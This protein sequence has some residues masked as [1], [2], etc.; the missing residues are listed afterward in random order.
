MLNHYCVKTGVM[1]SPWLHAVVLVA[2]ALPYFINLGVSSVWDGSE[3]F[4]AE[5]PREM[6]ATGDWLSPQFNFEP[7]VNK[8]PLTY[9]AVLVSYKLLG[10]HEFAVRLPGALAAL[11][12]MLFSWGAARMLFGSGAALVA[13]TIAAT[14]P[15][16]FILERRL[17]IDILLLF[18]LAGTLFFL[19]RGVTKGTPASWYGVYAFAALGFLTKGPVAVIVP[20]GALLCWMA[21]AR[22]MRLPGMRPLHGAAIF[23]CLT[24]PYYLLSYRVNGWTYIAPFFL[25]DNLGRFASESFGP[26]RGYFYYVLIWFS[27]FF[28]WAIILPAALFSL[29]RGLRERLKDPAFGLP[30]FWCIVIFL[31]FSLS[32]NKQEYYIAPMYPAAAILV[33]GFAGLFDEWRSKLRSRPSP[34]TP[35]ETRS[36]RLVLRSWG[37]LYGFLALLLFLMAFTLPYILDLLMPGVHFALR[38]VPS[39]ILVAGAVAMIRSV[40]RKDFHVAFA[41]LSFSLWILFFSGALVYVPALENFRPIKDF[42]R[43][44]EVE[45]TGTEFEAGYFRTAVPS[46]TFYLKHRIFEESDYRRMLRRLRADQ[47]TYCILDGRDYDW[48]KKR[49][50]TLHV[51]ER[52]ARFSVR[53]EQLFSEEKRADR[54]LLL[55]SNR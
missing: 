27:D 46:M 5:T 41:A 35:A 28:P 32:K 30:L 49:V 6:L 4:Y 17:P 52:R 2:L 43:R 38:V 11:G 21:Y 50:R 51:L 23:L 8:P 53:F 18:F 26:Q 12:I 47:R 20:A 54:E 19:L 37:W 16:I 1:H 33:A 55:I 34:M 14:T 31:F 10:V 22:K 29:R 3:A 36:E 45:A 44:I 40:V 25:S 9:W 48:F 13:A 42:C 7:R 39:L 24:L 15:R